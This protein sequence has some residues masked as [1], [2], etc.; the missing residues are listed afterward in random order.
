MAMLALWDRESWSTA[1]NSLARH[2]KSGFGT[3]CSGCDGGRGVAIGLTSALPA[4]RSRERKKP[5][6][7]HAT[8]AAKKA[9]HKKQ[10][11]FDFLSQTESS[12]L[13]S[14]SLHLMMRQI[15]DQIPGGQGLL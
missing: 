9:T 4:L 5:R 13:C 6:I 11:N 8:D 12:D 7:P 2:S 3:K 1:Q 15:R 10:A 14:W